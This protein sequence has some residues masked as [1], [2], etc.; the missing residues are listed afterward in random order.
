MKRKTAA[1]IFTIFTVNRQVHQTSRLLFDIGAGGGGGTFVY[2][3][4]K[5]HVAAGGG[6]GA[7]YGYNGGHGRTSSKGGNGRGRLSRSAIPVI[8]RGGRD[9]NAGFV[10]TYATNRS[11]GPGTG[12][13]GEALLKRQ[14][15]SGGG[16]GHGRTNV[17]S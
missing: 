10:N 7:A 12:W 6:G 14:S 3:K 4:T 13:Y 5:L 16:R 11:G 15:L 2:S 8:G 1:N 17:T 9:G